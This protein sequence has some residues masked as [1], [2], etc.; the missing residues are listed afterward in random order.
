[1][2]P[3]EELDLLVEWLGPNSSDQV[4]NIRAANAN[5]PCLGLKI[6]WERLVNEF[7]CPEMVNESLKRMLINVPTLSNKGSKKAL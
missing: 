2:T 4:L 3:F 5:N 7:G 1:M 6:Y